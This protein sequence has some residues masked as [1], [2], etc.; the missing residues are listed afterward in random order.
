MLD[1]LLN[2]A[3]LMEET[4]ISKSFMNTS[5]VVNKLKSAMLNVLL[6]DYSLL[7]RTL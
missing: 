4:N 6:I 7:R 1:H 5:E 3:P 2:L